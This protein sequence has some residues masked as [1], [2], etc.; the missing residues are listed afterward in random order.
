M[1]SWTTWF[2]EEIRINQA[3][4]MAETVLIPVVRL[5]VKRRR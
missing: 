5:A 2:R 4:E 3:D 1:K